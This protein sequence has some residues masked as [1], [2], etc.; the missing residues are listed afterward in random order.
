MTLGSD[1]NALYYTI[2]QYVSQV[3]AHNIDNTLE[4]TSTEQTDQ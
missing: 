4:V 2:Y 1:R 3:I